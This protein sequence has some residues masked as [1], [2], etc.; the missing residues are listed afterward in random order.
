MKT[1][2]VKGI[3]L[4]AVVSALTLAS[5]AAFAGSGIGGVFNLGKVNTVNGT[6]ALQ[7]S[8][9]GQQLHVVNSNTGTAA[10][11]IG[12]QTSATRPPLVVNSNVKVANLNADLLDGLDS[13][14]LQKRVTGACANGTAIA[15]IGA[16]GSVTCSTSAQFPIHVLVDSGKFADFF[17]GSG[18]RFQPQCRFGGAE[19][20]FFVQNESN[21]D[22]SLNWMFSQGGATST[23]NANGQTVPAGKF[24]SFNLSG[25]RLEGQ[26]IWADAQNVVTLRI[27]VLPDAAR[28]EFV[29]TALVAPTS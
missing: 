28:C 6:T 8:T 24:V 11:G 12:I 1:T 2:F 9:N 20:G 16:T 14:A 17:F 25:T 13:T 27:H 10:T 21:A 23:V 18:L 4:G 7:G 19:P 29:G 5:T 26:F 22:A 15:S 3:A